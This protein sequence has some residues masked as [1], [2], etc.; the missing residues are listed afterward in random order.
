MGTSIFSKYKP[1]PKASC[2]ADSKSWTGVRLKQYVKEGQ[3]RWMAQMPANLEAGDFR[4]PL[5]A[6]ARHVGHA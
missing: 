3:N 2:A 4:Q 5:S 6:A 1:T